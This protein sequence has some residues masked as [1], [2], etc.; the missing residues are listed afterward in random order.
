M[1]FQQAQK[2]ALQLRDEIQAHN[3]RYY[4]DNAPSISDFA[5]DLLMQELEGLEKMYPLL[6]TPDSPTQ[7]VGSDSI[8]EFVQIPH[9]YPMMSLSNTYSQGELRD[10]DLRV[11]RNSGT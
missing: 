5:F 8:K 6:K 2:R 1:N 11:R 7:R 10:F 4:V 3:K 9:K